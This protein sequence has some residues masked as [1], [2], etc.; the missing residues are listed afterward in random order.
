MLLNE[1]SS[2]VNRFYNILENLKLKIGP[3]YFTLSKMLSILKILKIFFI[4]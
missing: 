2:V 1:K 3:R 4:F